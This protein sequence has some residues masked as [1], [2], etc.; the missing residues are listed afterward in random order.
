LLALFTSRLLRV[1]EFELLHRRELMVLR[2]M[3]VPHHH[4]N[5][6]VTQHRRQR[7]KVNAGLGCSCSPSVPEIVEAE[8]GKPPP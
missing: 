7:Y 5:P 8:G 2:R 3:G 6:A 4:L 1:V